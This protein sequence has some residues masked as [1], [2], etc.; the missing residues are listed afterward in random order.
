MFFCLSKSFIIF[1]NMSAGTYSDPNQKGFHWVS[2]QY[3]QVIHSTLY[4]PPLEIIILI[5][6]Y[7]PAFQTILLLD[8]MSPREPQA[9]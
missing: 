8:W 5:Q 2:V 9:N 6:T 3:D 1:Q 7:N 4:I